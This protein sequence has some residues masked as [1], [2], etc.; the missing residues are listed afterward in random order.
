VTVRNANRLSNFTLAGVSGSPE[1]PIP[2]VRRFQFSS[3]AA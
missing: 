3:A 2:I 1:N